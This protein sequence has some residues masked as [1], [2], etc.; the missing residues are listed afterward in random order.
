MRRL[1]EDVAGVLSGA[2]S[3]AVG[4]RGSTRSAMRRR[5]EDLIGRMDL[6]TREEFEAVKEMAVRA[7]EEQARLADELAAA[8]SQPAEKTVPAAKPAPAARP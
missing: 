6:V 8:K 3:V 5:A 7:R 2:L 1:V 4:L